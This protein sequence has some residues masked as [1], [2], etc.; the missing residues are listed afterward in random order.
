MGGGGGGTTVSWT[1]PR[2]SPC[3]SEMFLPGRRLSSVGKE[4]RAWSEGLLHEGRQQP[5]T[6]ASPVFSCKGDTTWVGVL[7]AG[8]EAIL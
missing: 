6:E 2:H 8:E 4:S 7:L 1:Q 5:T 3:D